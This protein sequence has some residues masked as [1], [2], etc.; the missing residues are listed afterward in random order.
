MIVVMIYDFGIRFIML[1]YFI[2]I[3]SN[4]GMFLTYIILIGYSKKLKR[5]AYGN[6]YSGTT[7]VDN[8]LQ[9]SSKRCW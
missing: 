2:M 1:L 4:Y 7:S 6:Y 3:V 8:M 9:P 5:N